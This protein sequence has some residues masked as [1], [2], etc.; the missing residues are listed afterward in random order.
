[1]VLQFTV[2]FEPEFEWSCGGK[3]GGLFMGPEDEEGGSGRAH[4]P[5]KASARVMW[6]QNGDAIA[7][8]YVPEGTQNRQP[9]SEL[10][11]VQE[12]GAH[13]FRAHFPRVFADYAKNDGWHVVSIGIKPNTRPGSNDGKLLFGV[14]DT[15]RV[16]EG[17][18]WW[19]G[20][21]QNRLITLLDMDVFHGGQC[22][23]TR[24]SYVSFMNIKVGYWT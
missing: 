17:I 24:V 9:T 16:Q 4:A 11:G 23:A 5:N 13:L 22:S 8:V 14:D 3:L 12:E 19:Q 18:V 20:T 21:V 7:Y 10:R 15:V 1:M 2:R 6:K